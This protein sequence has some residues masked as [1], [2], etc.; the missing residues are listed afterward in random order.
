MTLQELSD[1][2]T[3][4]PPWQIAGLRVLGVLIAGWVAFRIAERVIDQ[5]VERTRQAGARAAQERRVHT[6][7]AVARSVV[8]YAINFVVITT[9]LSALGINTASILAGAGIVGLAVGFGAQSL[10]KDVITGFFIILENQ[11][12]VGEYLTAGGVSGFVEE[13][14]LRTSRLRDFTGEVHTIP[15][16]EIKITTNHSRGPMRALVDVGVAHEEDLS[17]VL[18]VLGR[19]MEEVRSDLAVI[20]REGPDVLGVVALGAP[21]VV[22]RIVASTVPLEQ[23]TVEREIRRRVKDAFEQAGIEMPY[24]RTVLVS[25]EAT[26]VSRLM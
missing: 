23:W 14:G 24:A 18:Q 5:V 26:R 15:N 21:E 11:Y 17:H 19:V 8:R 12:L 2:L 13:I 10:V 20:L 7:A 22:I 4:L 25:G 1:R 9:A 3:G 6:L 16:G